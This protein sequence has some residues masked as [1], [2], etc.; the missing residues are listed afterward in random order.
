MVRTTIPPRKKN[1]LKSANKSM[2]KKGTIGS[3]SREAK[4]RGKSV[5]TYARQV[6]KKL[7]GKPKTPNQTRLLRR[8]VF[9]NNAQKF[10][11]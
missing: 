1:W 2:K 7:K 11:K 8:A 9:A 4:A 3:F 6:I 10:N 5:P